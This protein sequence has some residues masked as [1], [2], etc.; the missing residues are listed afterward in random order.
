MNVDTAENDINAEADTDEFVVMQSYFR[1][2][3]KTK[4]SVP[5]LL[6]WSAT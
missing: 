4:R 3:D 5:G 1:S 6:Y 2:S